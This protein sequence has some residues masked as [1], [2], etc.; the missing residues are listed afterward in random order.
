[1]QQ[2]RNQQAWN[3]FRI[4]LQPNQAEFMRYDRY[5]LWCERNE[6]TPASLEAW[7]TVMKSIREY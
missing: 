3:N 5:K 2:T 6:V 1:M 4:K 7:Q